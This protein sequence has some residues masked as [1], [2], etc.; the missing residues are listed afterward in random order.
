MKSKFVNN[1]KVS[2]ITVTY[3]SEETIDDCLN[4]IV[5]QTYSNIEIFIIDD[6]SKYWLVALK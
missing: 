5:S 2:I 4:S 1:P 3:N 6:N